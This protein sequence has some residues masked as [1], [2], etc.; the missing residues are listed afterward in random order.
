MDLRSTMTHADAQRLKVSI[1]FITILYI[2]ILIIHLA[3]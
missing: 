3:W 1:V 2:H